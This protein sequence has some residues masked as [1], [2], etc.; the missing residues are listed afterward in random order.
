M[1][2]TVAQELYR[3]GVTVNCIGPAGL[4][5]ITATMPGVGRGV[6]ARRGARGRVEPD[7]PEEQLAG[8]GVAGERRSRL[9][10]RP[11]HP[12]ASTTS[13][14][15][16]AGGTSA[17]T[18]SCDGKPWDAEKLGMLMATEIFE[19]RHRG[20][21][22]PRPQ[23]GRGARHGDAHR[24]P[25]HRLHDQLPDR[26]QEGALRVHHQADEG[27]AVEGRVPVPGRVH[28]QGRARRGTTRARTR[29]RSRCARWTSTTSRRA[30]SAS[31]A[32]TRGARWSSTPTGSSPR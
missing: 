30:S 26:R 7:G 14:S 2:L 4:T 18:I 11:G 15:G 27:L 17:R 32:R 20:M 29:S 13:S 5:R 12:R 1:T 31:G 24:R 3:S 19:T 16:W 8:R 10:D 28:V 25:D 22:S 21:E 6:R 9:R 23:V